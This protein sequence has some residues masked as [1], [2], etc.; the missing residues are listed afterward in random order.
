MMPEE[1]LLFACC[2]QN[3]ETAHEIT[4]VDIC[5]EHQIN[6]QLIFDVASLHG[7]AP[8]L[9]SHL[10]KFEPEQL[11][12]SDV[13]LQQFQQC[14][15]ENMYKKEL[16][17][18]NVAEAL[19][20]FRARAI[21]VMLVKGAALDIL[22]YQQPFSTT[23]L[24]ADLILRCTRR[25]VSQEEF[26]HF[27]SIFH[28]RGLEYDFYEHHDINMNRVLPVDFAWIWQDARRVPFRNEQVWV[29]SPE[30]MLIAVC[31]NS[32]RKRFFRLKSLCDIRETV[33][34]YPD[35]D[36][37]TLARKANQ[38]QCQAIVYTALFVAQRT[39]GLDFPADL[40]HRMKINPVRLKL[41][42][43][44]SRQSSLAAFGSLYAGKVVLGRSID[45]ALLLSYFTFSSTQTVRKIA[46]ALSHT[47]NGTRRL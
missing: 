45:W 1:K 27:M 13:I 24:D 12:V 18:R 28:Q 14:L 11:G 3:L 26:Q 30:D 47:R 23:S 15:L 17:A 46:F 35:L 32:C 40:H 20:F 42:H 29:M 39:V 6:W 9:Y 37:S 10:R 33:G 7:I 43:Y 44:L 19:A 31:I 2:R 8:L 4:I 21:D 16:M 22:V 34:T 38:Y 36:W 5:R 41:L 25:E